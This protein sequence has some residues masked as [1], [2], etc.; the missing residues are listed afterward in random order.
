MVKT[1]YIHF[2]NSHAAFLARS[3]PDQK[4][5]GNALNALDILSPT[6]FTPA[7]TPELATIAFSAL[8]P[9]ATAVVEAAALPAHAIPIALQLP[10]L[11][12]RQ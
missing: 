3:P 10:C 11:P 4:T 6:I 12:I 5:C 2:A 8:N 1:E 9:V 7:A